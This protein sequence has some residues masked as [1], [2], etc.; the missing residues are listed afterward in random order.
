MALFLHCVDSDESR[1]ILHD[2]HSGVCGGHFSARTTT[3][4]IMH[5][6]YWKLPTLLLDPVIVQAPF[7]Q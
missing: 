3:H 2:L 6:G 1:D 4:K 5:V 7:Q